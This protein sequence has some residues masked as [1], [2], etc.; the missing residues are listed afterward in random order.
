MDDDRSFDHVAR[1]RP[2][3]EAYC[4]RMLGSLADAEDQAQ[5]TLVRAWRNIDGFEGRASL[6]AWLYKIATNACLD[7]LRRRPARALPFEQGPPLEP[8]APL[9]EPARE[10][11]WIDPCPDRLWQAVPAPPDA[12]YDARE[13]V[14]LA[15][16]A[17]LERLPGI[18]RAVLVLRDVLGWSAAE[19]AELTERSVPAVNSALQRARATLEER[20]IRPAAPLDPTSAALL[21]AYV[22]AWERGDVQALMRLLREDATAS[23]PPYPGWLRG[24]AALGAF[25]GK[26]MAEVA[27]RQRWLPLPCPDAGVAFY[28]ANAEGRFLAHALHLARAEGGVIVEVHAF[29]L[30]ALF[31]RFGLPAEI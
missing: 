24:P 20:V 15:F 14:R 9:G 19:V 16:M 7:E 23:M 13:S 6:R 26:R 1:F 17:A 18:Q 25:I 21:A 3:L 28:R 8:G 27:G 12:R 30:P 22:D 10:A 2:E 4:Y 11:T 29:L 5:E 31:P